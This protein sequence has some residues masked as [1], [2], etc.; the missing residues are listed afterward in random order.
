MCVIQK[1]DSQQGV[2]IRVPERPLRGEKKAD[3]MIY[4]CNPSY[5]GGRDQEDGGSMTA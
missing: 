1:S 2:S 4:A 5:S 3:M